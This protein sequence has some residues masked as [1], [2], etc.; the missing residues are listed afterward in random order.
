MEK[1]SRIFVGHILESINFIEKYVAGQNKET[2]MQETQVQAQEQQQTIWI[3]TILN[4]L[5]KIV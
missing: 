3:I 5:Q 1:E 2:F 4:A